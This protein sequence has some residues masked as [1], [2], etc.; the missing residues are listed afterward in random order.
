MQVRKLL[1]AEEGNGLALARQREQVAKALFNLGITATREAPV[2]ARS[3]LYCRSPDSQ[4]R[5]D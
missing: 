5:S 3:K 4:K 1:K 2:P